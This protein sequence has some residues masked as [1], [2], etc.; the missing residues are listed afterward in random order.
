MGQLLQS[1][2]GLRGGGTWRAGKSCMQNLKMD[3]DF[4]KYSVENFGK[5]AIYK[6]Q[7]C[8]SRVQENMKI[9]AK[10]LSKN[11]TFCTLYGTNGTRTKKRDCPVKYGTVGRPGILVRR[12]I[13][14]TI[15]KGK[16]PLRVDRCENPYTGQPMVLRT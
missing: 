10:L 13:F 2:S 16:I 8:E 3:S 1:T 4:R 14:W 9:L 11:G 15:K 12:N 5:L 6:G 7:F